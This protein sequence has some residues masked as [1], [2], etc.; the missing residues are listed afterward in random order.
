MSLWPAN[1]RC[2][3][4]LGSGQLQDAGR[5]S[6]RWGARRIAFTALIVLFSLLLLSPLS[7]MAAVV[8]GWFL[9]PEETGGVSHRVHDLAFGAMF[10][11]A[12]LGTVS[13]L[14][15]AWWKVAPMQQ[16]IVAIVVL[17]VVETAISGLDPEFLPVLASF[18]LPVLAI[19]LLHP[20][21]GELVH[22]SLRPSR[23]LG[24][25]AVLAVVPLLVAAVNQAQVGVSAVAIANRPEFRALEEVPEEEFEVAFDE[26]LGAAGL[27]PQTREEVEH[28]FHWPAMA[29]FFLIV[30]IIITLAALRVRGWRLTAWTAGLVVA[31]YGLA[32]FLTPLDASSA[33]RAGGALAMAWALLFIVIAEREIRAPVSVPGGAEEALPS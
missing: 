24:V 27:D 6:P 20:A 5:S 33:G 21:R 32:S 16:A 3:L 4:R 22:P 14:R 25:M 8:L 28:F 12:F 11:I 15:S 17:V 9:G 31:Y 7:P 23:M 19:G 10:T 29:S 26:A 13:Q 1:L 30:A 18:L 2:R